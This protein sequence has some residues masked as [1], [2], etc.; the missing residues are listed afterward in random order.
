MCVCVCVCVCVFVY[1]SAACVFPTFIPVYVLVACVCVKS[2][3][4]PPV[5]QKLKKKLYKK[6]NRA[7]TFTNFQ[8]EGGRA[9]RK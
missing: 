5:K 9:F 2:A 8:G 1:T 6:Y 7:R 4:L 3:C